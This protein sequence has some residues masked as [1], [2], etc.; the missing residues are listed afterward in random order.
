MLS[1][2]VQQ[3][4][5]T[6]KILRTRRLECK[7]AA[8]NFGGFAAIFA[9]KF[10]ERLGN[11]A[12]KIIGRAAPHTSERSPILDHAICGYGR[13]RGSAASGG[14]LALTPFLR[15]LTTLARFVKRVVYRRARAFGVDL[16]V[17]ARAR[18]CC[19]ERAA[20]ATMTAVTSSGDGGGGGCRAN[21][22]TRL[23]GCCCYFFRFFSLFSAAVATV[24][25]HARAR[26]CARRL[27]DSRAVRARALFL[28]HIRLLNAIAILTSANRDVASDC[29]NGERRRLWGRASVSARLY[30]FVRARAST[31]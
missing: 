25:T 22:V 31:D 24:Y 14:T 30:G 2:N 11:V 16:C 26:P 12:L 10:L 3:N 23:V 21:R 7:N 18:A 28:S 29:S 6:Q 5:F 9:A 19:V 17:R 15:A 20:T 4:R 13:E 8:A 27:F 1:R